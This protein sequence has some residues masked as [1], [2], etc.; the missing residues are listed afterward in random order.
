[1][2]ARTLRPTVLGAVL[3]LALGPAAADAATHTAEQ[4]AVVAEANQHA[5]AESCGQN[6]LIVTADGFAPA[7]TVRIRQLS[8]PGWQRVL[9]S[10]RAGRLVVR[11]TRIDSRA[12]VITFVGMGETH[13]AAGGNVSVSVPR[14][15][16]YRIS[17]R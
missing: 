3:L 14:I 11:V 9:K 16:V 4:P 7:E 2:F 12:D 5:V 13:P 17:P 8:R 15:A 1:M 10:D 6:C